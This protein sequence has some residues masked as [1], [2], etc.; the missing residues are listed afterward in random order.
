MTC[1][2]AEILDPRVRRTRKL[3]QEALRSLFVEKPFASISIQDITERATVNRATFY[4]HYKDKKELA[5]SVIK[6]DLDDAVTAH[7]AGHPPLTR[8]SLIDFAVVVFEF[9]G[10][11]D[12]RCPSNA[13]ELQEVA[14][15]TL[16]Q[17][18]Y[19]MLLHWLT[20]GGAYK[21]L[22]PGC[23][24]E[25]AASVLSWSIYG[26][27]LDWSRRERRAPAIK[28]CGE[29]IS[30]L[31]PQPGMDGPIPRRPTVAATADAA[32]H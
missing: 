28:V 23:T 24:K 25:T 11:H 19:A 4:A 18:L 13:S 29:I 8:Q 20:D 9:L 30:V 21:R 1:P 22:F 31:L 27:A 16:Q 6:A 17:S 12:G 2:S 32:R 7:F 10:I 14:G 3:L 5:A 15:A 26:G